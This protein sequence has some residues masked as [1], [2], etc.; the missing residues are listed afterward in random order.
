MWEKAVS[1]Y[2]TQREEEKKDDRTIYRPSDPMPDEP[3]P[4][5]GRDD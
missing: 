5:P 2:T 4:H 3:P 1:I